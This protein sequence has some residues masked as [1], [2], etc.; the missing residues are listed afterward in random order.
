[1]V[2]SILSDRVSEKANLRQFISSRFSL[3]ELKD[4]TFDLGVDYESFPHNSKYED[5]S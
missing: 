4:L 1:M 3:D 2:A 5:S